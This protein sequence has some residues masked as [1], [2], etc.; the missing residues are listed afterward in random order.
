MRKIIRDEY[1]FIYSFKEWYFYYRKLWNLKP[2]KIT[3]YK[4]TP[5]KLIIRK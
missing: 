5:N 3:K 1:H 4:F 2:N